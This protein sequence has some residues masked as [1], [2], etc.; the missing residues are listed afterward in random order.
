MNGLAITTMATGFVAP[1]VAVNYGV[2]S[3]SGTLLLAGNQGSLVFGRDQP[4]YGGAGRSR[5][6]EGVTFLEAYVLFGIPLMLLALA[7]IAVV[8]ARWEDLRNWR[9]LPGD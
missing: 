6:T 3:A 1:L 5:R 9:D 7:G 4:T 2:S 8:W